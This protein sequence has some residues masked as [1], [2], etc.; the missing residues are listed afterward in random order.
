MD[1]PMSAV[2]LATNPRLTLLVWSKLMELAKLVNDAFCIFPSSTPKAASKPI[3]FLV[4]LLFP[5]M[6]TWASW[7]AKT[8]VIHALNW[9][10]Q[11]DFIA[12]QD[13]TLNIRQK[14]R[15]I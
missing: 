11:I 13:F 14:Y 6:W 9:I 4:V 10:Y 1:V 3:L 12:V 8:E 5:K 15:G 7:S 2:Y